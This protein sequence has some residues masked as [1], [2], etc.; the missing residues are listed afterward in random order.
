VERLRTIVL[1]MPT[2]A[3][4]ERSQMSITAPTA[5]RTTPTLAKSLVAT[6]L[7]LVI[8]GGIAYATGAIGSNTVPKKAARA[9]VGPKLSIASYEAA[10]AAAGTYGNVPTL[11]YLQAVSASPPPEALASYKAAAAAAG[12]YGNVPTL[13][14]LAAISARPT[15]EALA[16]YKA[17]VK[18]AGTYGNVP[19]LQ[20]LEA[21][22]ANKSARTHGLS[23]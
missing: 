13:Q 7:A 15:P 23:P 22:A 19:T 21:I 18:A 11:Q 20:Y 8:A 16:S 3:G 12:T 10:V 1:S 17:A 6:V 2:F 9:A 14:Y 4:I 5:S